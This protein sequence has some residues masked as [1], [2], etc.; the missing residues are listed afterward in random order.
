M[1]AEILLPNFLETR[2]VERMHAA[3]RINS[4]PVT[5]KERNMPSKSKGNI[6]TAAN[7]SP[8]QAEETAEASV[9]NAAREDEIRLR[10]YEIYLQRGG[11][12]GRE[13]DDWLKAERELERGALGRLQ[14]S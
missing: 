4:N 9:R 12:P 8:I 7:A 1:R 6:A 13:M 14:A 11:E 5:G 10:A 3:A 2:R